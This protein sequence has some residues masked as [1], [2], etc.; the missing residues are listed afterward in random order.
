MTLEIFQ[1][2]P[3][4]WSWRIRKGKCVVTESSGHCRRRLAIEAAQRWIR[5]LRQRDPVLS[6]IDANP[7][8]QHSTP[9]TIPSIGAFAASLLPSGGIRSGGGP[10]RGDGTL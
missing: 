8:L 9:P 3:N 6:V 7:P 5:A 10:A 4:V 2:S 1:A